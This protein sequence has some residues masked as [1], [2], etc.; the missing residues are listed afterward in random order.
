MK[1]FP[2]HRLQPFL[3][4]EQES[5]I[6]GCTCK[7]GPNKEKVYGH[8]SQRCCFR[9]DNQLNRYLVVDDLVFVRKNII[10]MVQ[11]LGGE[12]RGWRKLAMA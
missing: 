1:G 5:E 9:T 8:S 12:R 7:P 4:G 3:N 10:K 11:L 6:R 2:F